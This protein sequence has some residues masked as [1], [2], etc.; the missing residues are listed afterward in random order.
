MRYRLRWA[1]RGKLRYV[2]HHDEALIFER[3]FRR[4]GLPLRYSNGFSAHPKIAFGSGLP[5]GYGS[6]VEL[7]DVGLTRPLDPDAIVTTCNEGLPSGLQILGAAALPPGVP[8]LGSTIAA[9]DYRVTTSQ[10]WVAEMLDWFLGLD[11]YEITRPYKGAERTDDVRA[12][13]LG[14]RATEGGFCVRT[15]LKPRA[16]RPADMFA[17]MGTKAGATD[18]AATFERVAL[19]ASAGDDLITMTESSIMWEVAG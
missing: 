3:S 16:V 4:A 14:A 7:M 8:S 19:L 15:R 2:S 17:A 12:G 13:V 6:E 1:K 11:S 5:V 18:P 9:A 10:P